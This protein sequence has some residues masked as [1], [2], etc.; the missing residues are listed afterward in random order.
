V[1]TLNLRR[2]ADMVVTEEDSAERM[3]SIVPDVL[4]ST[5]MIGFIERVCAELMAEHLEEGESSV[6][7]GFELTHEA[8][9]P[10]GMTVRVSVE[11][12]ELAGRKCVFAVEARDALDVIGRGRHTRAVIDRRRFMERVAQKARHA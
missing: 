12:V 5:R 7:I 9:T 2:E 10:I 11:L 3:I 6:G 4:A 1:L 8:P